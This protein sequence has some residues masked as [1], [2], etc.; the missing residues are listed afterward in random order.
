MKMPEIPVA[1]LRQFGFRRV[2]S[3]KYHLF[4]DFNGR[5]LDLYQPG[6]RAIFS[7]FAARALEQ[8][9]RDLVGIEWGDKDECE[10]YTARL[11]LRT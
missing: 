9:E 11:R 7:A 1:E 3:G 4:A 6:G 5:G 8:L 2:Y 10:Y